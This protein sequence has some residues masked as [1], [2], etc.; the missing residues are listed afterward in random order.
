LASSFHDGAIAIVNSQGD[1]VYAEAT[2]RPLQYKRSIGMT[3]DVV[4]WSGDVIR[5]YCEPDAQLV[6]AY[7]WDD[8]RIDERHVTSIDSVMTA[9]EQRGKMLPAAIHADFAALRFS[10]R[11]IPAIKKLSGH[12]LDYE[13]SRIR[14]HGRDICARRSYDHHRTHAAAACFSSPFDEAVC[15]IVDGHGERYSCAFFSFRGGEIKQIGPQDT[16]DGSLGFFYTAICTA[17][18]FAPFT[19]E[20][21]KVMGL[22]GYGQRDPALLERLRKMIQVDG[23]RLSGHHDV[24]TGMA[25]HGMA[26]PKGA[27]RLAAAN[28][29]FAGQ[30]VFCEVLY[31]LLRNLRELGISDNL[32]LGGGCAL[33]SAAT[34]G[35]PEHTGFKHVHVFSAPG[36]DGNAVGAALLAHQEDHPEHR[37]TPGIMLPY[38][39]SRLSAETLDNVRRFSGAKLT[40]CES[41]APERAARLLAQ[42]K[43]LGWVQGRAE[44]GPRALGNR[45]ILADPRRP[46]IREEIN[47]RVKFR[48][49]FRP[50]APS[51]LHEYG[52]EYFESYCESPYM[53][54]ALKFREEVKSRVPGVVHVDGTGRL[55]TVKK[56]WNERYHRLIRTF[57]SITGIPLVL[58]TSFNVMGKP[59]A[60]S[61]EDVLAVF[62]STGLDAV[63]IEDLLIEK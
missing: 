50:L 28:V 55:Q 37:R 38:L 8:N 35:I 18:G 6:T 30:Q 19:G 62:Y 34:G 10:H 1:V 11:L 47:N 59:I 5:E 9:L 44:F 12:N 49:E 60:H 51:I 16:G 7:S 14:W 26:P 63:F 15:A 17:C 36:D 27:S 46:G 58:N 2:E 31:Q 54:R 33:N 56:E 3:P 20:E 23:L 48:E 53:E 40:L 57:H 61:V 25:L 52:P 24:Q 32:I 42:G 45:S 41:D 29:A 4:H 22:A 13:L 21:W 39:G 43:I